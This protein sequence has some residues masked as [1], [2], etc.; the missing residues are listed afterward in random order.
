[1]ENETR[2][3]AVQVVGPLEHMMERTTR[4]EVREGLHVRLGCKIKGKDQAPR[5]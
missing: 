4:I 5:Q 1:M 3:R 2:E